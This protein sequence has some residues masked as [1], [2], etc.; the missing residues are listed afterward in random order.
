MI[1]TTECKN[2]MLN[3]IKSRL[4]QRTETA[5]LRFYNSSNTLLV[6]SD[7]DNITG[8]V[9]A[10][11]LTFNPTVSST[12]TATG[13]VAKARI[14]ADDNVLMFDDLSVK[15]SDN[16]NIQADVSLSNLNVQS[17]GLLDIGA[18]TIQF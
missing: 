16:T 7:V 17:G 10:S 6:E 14:Y 3:G 8:T 1:L 11:V 9:D 18:I 5:K 4:N 13:T 2:A 15:Q 12:V